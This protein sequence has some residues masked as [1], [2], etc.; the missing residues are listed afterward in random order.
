MPCNRQYGRGMRPGQPNH[1]RQ[2][3]PSNPY[4]TKVRNS[5]VRSWM[6][7][8]KNWSNFV[9]ARVL[10]SQRPMSPN[11]SLNCRRRRLPLLLDKVQCWTLF[12]RLG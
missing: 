2:P 6:L 7:P 8:N 11:C 10:R 5:S 12:F 3:G 4:L 1:R 9:L